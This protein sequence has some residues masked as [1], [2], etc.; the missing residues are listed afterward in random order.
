MEVT[1]RL[2]VYRTYI[3]DFEISDSDRQYIERTIRV[4]RERTPAGKVSP[5]AFTFLRRVLL[6][7]PPYYAEE[8]KGRML[9]F[10]MRWQQFAGPVMAKGLEDT[11]YYRY[12]AL[13]SMNEV[14]GDP[15]RVMPPM[16]LSGFHEFNVL[17]QQR[18]AGGLSATSTHD[19][20]RGEDARAR[21]NVLSEIPREWEE[22]FD[23]WS[24]LNEPLKKKV[25]G[26]VAPGL[27]EEFLIYQTLLGTYPNDES[28]LNDYPARLRDFFIKAAREAK[29]RTSWLCPDADYEQALDAFTSGLL[30]AGSQ[31]QESFLPFQRKVAFLGAVNGLSQVLLKMA[32]PGVPNFYQGTEL[33]SFSMV[34]PDNRRPVDYR[35]RAELLDWL[36][37]RE[38]ED[39]TILAADLAREP[40]KDAAKLY[41]VWKA[42]GF[43]RDHFAL[44]SEGDYIPVAAVGEHSDCVVA[45]ARRRGGEWALA[46]APRWITQLDCAP[47]DLSSCNWGD[48][49]LQLPPG[50]PENWTNVFTGVTGKASA[51]SEILRD[52]PVALLEGRSVGGDESG[53]AIPQIGG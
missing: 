30:T 3:R 44:F 4:A 48:T 43:R 11:A 40:Q 10:V 25:G 12:N 1:A 21:I 41:V 45:F 46:V 2:P 31:F 32:C 17:R 28:E 53:R 33:W 6:L 27:N 23:R 22:Q 19:A 13:I 38:S 36:R 5:E 50:A 29:Q 20:K 16:D 47:P 35:R 14:G 37:S 8:H 26:S 24:R 51:M 42:L 18:W 9:A 52:F 49:A 15:L 39:R 7:D 34:D